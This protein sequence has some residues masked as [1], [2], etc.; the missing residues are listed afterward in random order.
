MSLA[1]DEPKESDEVFANDGVKYII[2]P[3]LVKR[4]GN[5][6][7]DFVDMGWRSGFSVSSERPVLG[8]G[9]CSPGGSCAPQGT[10]S[11]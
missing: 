10:C 9:T 11:C 2:D 5:I 7:I 4:T 6:T 8:G 3:D 1:L